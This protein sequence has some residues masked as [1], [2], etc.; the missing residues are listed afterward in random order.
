MAIFSR[1][2]SS[3]I[4]PHFYQSLMQEISSNSEFKNKIQKL[5]E[6]TVDDQDC[7]IEMFNVL[8]NNGLM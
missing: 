5:L 8:L 2:E 7:D 1:I 3:N 4:E 6:D